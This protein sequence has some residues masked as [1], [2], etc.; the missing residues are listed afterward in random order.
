MVKQ[1]YEYSLLFLK[2]LMNHWFQSVVI[3]II[4]IVFMI[5]NNKEWLHQPPD[6]FDLLS[7]TSGWLGFMITF[8][9]LSGIAFNLVIMREQGFL[10][11]FL[12]ISG[13]V[14]PIILGTILAQFVVLT[15]TVFIFSSVISVLF[16][17]HFI[18]LFF[19]SFLL[20]V[21][22]LLPVSF[23]TLWIP[24]L[25]VKKESLSPIVSLSIIPLLYFTSFNIGFE[26]GWIRYFLVLNPVEFIF[27][28][29]VLLFNAI[30]DIN[31]NLVFSIK[32]IGVVW[33]LYFF[34][35]LFFLKKVKVNAHY[36]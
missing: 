34:V 14:V 28:L 15:V 5:W 17:S 9:I 1:S 3:I 33:M 8:A 30:F 21:L 10:K 25:S 26:N 16:H 27:Q 24:A 32:Y 36:R 6:Q 35:G 2:V 23:F 19:G 29:S 20:V 11:M 13:S 22:T 7:V 12:F 31:R 4:P 18:L